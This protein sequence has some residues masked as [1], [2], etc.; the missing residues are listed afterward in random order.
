MV[1]STT[2]ELK[3][4]IPL[5]KF[6]M[7]P[8]HHPERRAITLSEVLYALSDPVRMDIVRKLARVG[9]ACCGEIDPPVAKSTASHHFKVLREAGVIRV[10]Q[11]GT[12]RCTS[13]RLDD[14]EQRFPGLLEAI[15]SASK[16]KG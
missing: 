4:T 1:S 6:V 8:L 13:L 16:N 3:C 14:L 5:V 10:R 12:Q 15:L 11:E 7:K 2:I 9:E